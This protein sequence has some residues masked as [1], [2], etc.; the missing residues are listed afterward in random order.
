MQAPCPRCHEAVDLFSSWV[1]VRNA[2]P[3][4]KPEVKNSPVPRATLGSMVSTPT[5]KQCVRLATYIS[6]QRSGTVRGANATCHTCE[7]IFSVRAAVAD[8]GACPSFRLYGKL[9][10]TNDGAKEYLPATVADQEAYQSC[11]EILSDELKRESFRLPT[12]KLQDGYNTRQAMG[13]GFRQWR[14]FFNARQLLALG[15]L[16][17]AIASLPEDK[18]RDVF[19][20]LFSGALEFNNMFASYKGEGTAAVRHMF[21]HHILKPERTPIEAQSLGHCQ[22]FGVFF[23]AI[24]GPDSYSY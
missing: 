10:L 14:D 3:R 7:H 20:T 24:P 18:G 19:L 21:A 17:E 5:Q 8:P 23:G 16:H 1:R 11:V 13:Y 2:Y 12:L 22:E 15:W 6:T 4:R 9:I